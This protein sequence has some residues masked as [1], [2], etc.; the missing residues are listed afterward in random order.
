M[1]VEFPLLRDNIGYL[2]VK[3]VMKKKVL[4]CVMPLLKYKTMNR[5]LVLPSDHN[6]YVILID[7]VIRHN[8]EGIF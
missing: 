7:D 1:I 4:K 3:L 8:L 6:Q 5:F 2:A